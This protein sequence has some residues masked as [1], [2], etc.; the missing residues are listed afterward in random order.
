MAWRTSTGCAERRSA[1]SEWQAE[2]SAPFL[3]SGGAR[4]LGAQPTAVP[5]VQLALETPVGPR[6]NADHTE[7]D[8]G[9]QRRG[10]ERRALALTVSCNPRRNVVAE[11]DIVSGM[12][13]RLVQ[14]DQV[15]ALEGRGGGRA[16]RLGGEGGCAHAP[17]P[18]PRS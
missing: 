14:A 6:P 16:C 9:G 11:P 7:V 3:L 5:V 10:Q 15:A 4:R 2:L 12:E 17:R 1:T 8:A 13:I 18:A